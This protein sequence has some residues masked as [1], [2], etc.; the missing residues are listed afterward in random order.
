MTRWTSLFVLV[1]D[2]AGSGTDESYD[3]ITTCAVVVQ[4]ADHSKLQA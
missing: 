4:Q 2:L 3:T 1:E